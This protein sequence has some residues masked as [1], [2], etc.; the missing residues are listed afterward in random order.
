[1]LFRSMPGMVC[2]FRLMASICMP[3]LMGMQIDAISLNPQT[4]PGIKHIIRQ[5]T[6][7]DC[8]KLLKQVLDSPTVARTNQLVRETIFQKFPDQLSFFYSLLDSEEGP[9]Q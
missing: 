8:K 1:M 3:I 7:D 9:S 4:I 6:M 5:T 2:G